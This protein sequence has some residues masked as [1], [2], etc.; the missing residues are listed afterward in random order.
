MP[1]EQ[2]GWHFRQVQR[3]AQCSY[4]VGSDGTGVIITAVIQ[5]EGKALFDRLNQKTLAE[6]PP[7]TAIPDLGDSAMLIS[8]PGARFASVS[9]VKGVTIVNII[10]N[11]DIP[12]AALQDAVIA[13]ARTV[14]TRL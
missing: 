1:P 2:P 12:Y 11:K 14:A 5:S 6:G 7:A 10:L 4:L 13:L 9:F 3:Q 8:A